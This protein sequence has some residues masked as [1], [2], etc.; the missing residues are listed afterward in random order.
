MKKIDYDTSIYNFKDLIK[1]E[2]NV[3]DLDNIQSNENIFDRENDQKTEFHKKY[4]RLARKEKFQELYSRFLK[5]VIS[6]E[7]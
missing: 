2:F 3:T 6:P 4:Y 1:E 7:Y 5:E